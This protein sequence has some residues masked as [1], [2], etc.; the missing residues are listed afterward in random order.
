MIADFSTRYGIPLDILRAIVHVES[1]GDPCAMRFEPGYRW[2][3]DVRQNRPW[4]GTPDLFPAPAGVSRD[5]ERM[6]QMT[7]WGPMQVMGAVAREHG[8]TGKYLSALC[9]YEIGMHY[10]C[11]HLVRYHARYG[12]W[13]EA[14]VSYNAGSPRKTRDGRWVNEGYLRKLREAGARL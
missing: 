14:V 3:W 12:S 8:F 6:G 9:R 2:L 1:S 4:L 11:Q 13:E 10:G 7:S 5:T